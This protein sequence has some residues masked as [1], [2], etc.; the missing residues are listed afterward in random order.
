MGSR[1][2]IVDLITEKK[3]G[4]FLLFDSDLKHYF[5]YYSNRKRVH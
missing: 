5:L 4:V 2:S 3:M 1:F